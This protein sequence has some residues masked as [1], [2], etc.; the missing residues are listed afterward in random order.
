MQVIASWTGGQADALRQSLRMTNESFAGYLGVAARTVAY[1]RRQPD[2]IP[3]AAIQE[4]LD[5]ALERAPARAKAQFALL[6][7]EAEHGRRAERA[8][9]F[10][11]P[12]RVP[13]PSLSPESSLILPGAGMDDV[14][15]RVL[16]GQSMASDYA[17]PNFSLL[18]ASEA[19]RREMEDTLAAGTV[20]SARLDRIEETVAAH[21]RIYTSTPPAAALAGLLADFVDVRRLCAERQPAVIQGRL[22][23]VAALLATLAADS[24]MKLGQVSEARAW[25]GTARI[26]ADDTCNRELRARVRAQEA[27]LPYY[28]GDLGDVIRLVRDAQGILDGTPCAAG[29][30]ALAGEARALSRRPGCRA[31]AER[32]MA[33]AQDLVARIREPDNDEAFR[34]GERRLFFYLSSTLTNLGESARA[35]RI[36]DEALTLYGDAPGL[37]DPTLIRLD[38][39]QI[40]TYEGDLDSARNLAQQTCLALTSEH[41]APIVAARLRQIMTAIPE[42]DETH[43]ALSELRQTVI[44]ANR[45]GS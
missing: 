6:T 37:I 29:A 20:T 24:L 21:I 4:T 43:H 40:L 28:Y 13:A 30:L 14:A 35:A 27:M 12:V 18:A 9:A 16:V 38:Q 19:I 23:E 22:C 31:D 10:E 15:R 3:K 1:W 42:T 33:D 32:A 25:Y 2:M 8:E 7:G 41:R 45:S 34:F 17:P 11:M 44:K 26:A 39:V 5:A 36:Q